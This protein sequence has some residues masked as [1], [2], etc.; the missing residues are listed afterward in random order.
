MALAA[1]WHPSSGHRI[2]SWP[3]SAG[4]DLVRRVLLALS[5]ALMPFVGM[6]QA[7][8]PLIRYEA[9]YS[10]ETEK[11]TPAISFTLFDLEDSWL[12][13][14]LEKALGLDV[15][16][17]ARTLLGA[18]DQRPLS[19][20]EAVLVIP[21]NERVEVFGGIAYVSRNLTFSFDDGE[22]AITA[23]VTFKQ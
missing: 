13:D 19:G 17:E 18:D 15:G 11:V 22:W 1:G 20:F 3:D 10:F 21:M 5:I 7:E 12:E 4:G 23:G 9:V 6:A 2:H 16:I 14:G 8:P